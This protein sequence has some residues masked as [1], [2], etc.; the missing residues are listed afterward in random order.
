MKASALILTFNHG[1]FVGQAI[2]GF[3][4]QKTD[5]PC[6]LVIA[7]DCSTDNTREVIRPYWEAHRDRIRVL[8][9]RRNIGGRR[10]IAR[11]YQACRGQ[12]VAAF[13]GDDYWTCPDKL[14]RQVDLLE[15]HPTYALCF[16]S[17]RMV[18]DDGSREPKV[19]RPR[20]IKESYTLKDLFEYDFIPSCS[21]VYRKGVFREHPGWYFV[22]PV[23]DWPHHVL[24]AQY[25]EIG[26]IDEPMAVY[27]QH[28][29]G[30]YSG[31]NSARKFRIAIEVLRRFRCVA[32]REYRH[33]I[34]QSLCRHYCALAHQYCDEGRLRE[35]RGCLLECFQE[36]HP[37]PLLLFRHLLGV[38]ARACSP[39]LHRRCRQVLGGVRRSAAR[40]L[41]S[42]EDVS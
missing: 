31:A 24:H 19:L 4:L 14:Q 16:H 2:E 15:R 20:Q 18:W 36:V 11:A 7:D 13:D 28:P 41:D 3:L 37:G 30:T 39:G 22:P 8:L 21:V 17:A 27:R 25:G 29:G 9:N 23:G 10:T 40:P 26:Y 34:D 5:F 33:T 32:A 35:A 12:Y 6:E 42:Q 1:R 38:T